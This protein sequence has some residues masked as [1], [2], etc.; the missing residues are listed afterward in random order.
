MPIATIMQRYLS[1]LQQLPCYNTATAA[2][3]QQLQQ[4]PCY[5][6]ATAAL[7]QHC[8]CCLATK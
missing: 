5:K 2:L 7:L 1:T 6:T 4:L 8:N 3:L